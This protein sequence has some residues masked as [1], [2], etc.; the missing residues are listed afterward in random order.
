[1]IYKAALIEERKSNLFYVKIVQKNVAI[2]GCITDGLSGVANNGD[3]HNLFGM[4]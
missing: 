4:D 3:C 1:M 2:A